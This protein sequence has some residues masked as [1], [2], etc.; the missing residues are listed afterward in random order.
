VYVFADLERLTDAQR[1]Q[2]QAVWTTLRSRP[3]CR[4]LN[5]PAAVLRRV[6]LLTAL[7]ARGVNGFRVHPITASADAIRFPVFLRIA[8][9][10]GGAR[11]GLL[12]DAAALA[13]QIA[14]LRAHGAR[15]ADWITVE[16]CDTADAGGFYRKYSAFRVGEGLIPRHLFVGRAWCLKAS[17]SLQADHVAEERAYV[18]QHPHAA[19]LRELFD[20]ARLEYGRIDYGVLDGRIQVWEINTNPMILTP[21]HQREQARRPVHERFDA[22]LSQAWAAL[23]VQRRRAGYPGEWLRTLRRTGEHALTAARH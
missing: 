9:D 5:E 19:T 7:H 11:T 14:Q 1:A 4:V 17:E 20:L 6:D 12:R 23:D 18:E 8:D 21:A 15:L 16:F 22:Q 2:A 10:H 13:G 3:D